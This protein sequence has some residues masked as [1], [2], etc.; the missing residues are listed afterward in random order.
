[1]A[2]LTKYQKADG[3]FGAEQQLPNL[4][5]KRD[6]PILWGNGRLLVGL[7]EVYECRGDPTALALARKLGDYLVATDPV[8]DQAENLRTVGGS[9]ADGFGTC[10]FSC[11]EGLAALGRATKDQRYIV[12]A[13][14]I[15]AARAVGHQFRRTPQPRPALRRARLRRTLCADRPALLVSGGGTG[16]ALFACRHLL[17]T[18][19]VKE[20]L[21]ANCIRDEGCAEADWLRL[22]LLLWRLTGEGRFLDAAERALKNH[23][24]YQ[25]FANGGAGHRLLHQI[26][27]QPVAFKGLSEEAWWCC[28]EHWARA[29]VEVARSAVVAAPRGPFIALALDCDTSLPAPA[30]FGEPPCA[31]RRRASPSA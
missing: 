10:Y 13:T 3:H 14:H 17:P 18:G 23:F 25:Q 29:M 4:E 31:K 7:V 16:L 15:A 26:G 6:M 21:D 22:N 24:L 2:G 12:E 27:G 1:M 19:G 28:G 5:R 30:D 8:Y 11:I 20:I 9:H